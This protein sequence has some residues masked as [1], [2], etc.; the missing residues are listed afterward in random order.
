M[1]RGSDSRKEA[2]SDRFE[3][4]E[5]RGTDLIWEKG[6]FGLGWEEGADLAR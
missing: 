1:V 2:D 3:W 5:A 6:G 4:E